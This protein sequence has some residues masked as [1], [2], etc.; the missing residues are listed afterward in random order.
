[1]LHLELLFSCSRM[2]V[3]KDHPSD[4]NPKLQVSG[5]E[6]NLPEPPEHAASPGNKAGRELNRMPRGQENEQQVQ[7][8]G[9]AGTAGRQQEANH[10]WRWKPWAH[11]RPAPA[12]PAGLRR[13]REWSSPPAVRRSALTTSSQLCSPSPV[14]TTVK[15][16]QRQKSFSLRMEKEPAIDRIFQQLLQGPKAKLSQR[17]VWG[18][19][20]P[21][22]QPHHAP[23]G[24]CRY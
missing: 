6:A 19:S 24:I 4:L 12:H 15:K 7:A 8:A 16:V 3:S 18:G 22:T 17:R 1:M 9:S 11:S 21:P 2:G 13:G 5:R 10:T 20:D 23:V 14:K